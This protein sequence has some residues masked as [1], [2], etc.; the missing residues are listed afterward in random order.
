MAFYMDKIPYN[1][2][3]CSIKFEFLFKGGFRC[4][5]EHLV[6]YSVKKFMYEYDTIHYSNSMLD[7]FLLIATCISFVL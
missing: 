5:F 4:P 3:L 1:N 6:F 2:L 7:N